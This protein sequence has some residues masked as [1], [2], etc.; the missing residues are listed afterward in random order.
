MLLQ[1]C[2]AGWMEEETEFAVIKELGR[3]EEA[4][5]GCRVGKERAAVWYVL[6]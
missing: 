1:A 5:S 2:K 3:E 6:K 4:A